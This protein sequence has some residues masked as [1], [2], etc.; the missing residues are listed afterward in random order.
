MKK[1]K[2]GAKPHVIPLTDAMLDVLKSLPRFEAGD[3]LFSHSFGKRPLKPNQFSDPKTRLDRRM[4]WTLRA[5]ARLRGTGTVVVR[6]WVNHDIRRTVRTHLSAL[7]IPEEVREAMLAHVRPGIKG[8]Y[9]KYEY[10][11]EKREALVSWAS[12]LREIVEPPPAN[13]VE[14]AKARGERDGNS[15][16]AEPV[17]RSIC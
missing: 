8:A 12:R 2:G 1:V 13:V 7:K 15:C 5:I 11:D 17:G 16:A 14:F 9:D 4:L 6:D 10:L 3:F